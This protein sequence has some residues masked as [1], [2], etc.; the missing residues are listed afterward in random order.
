MDQIRAIYKF[1]LSFLKSEWRL[2]DYPIRYQH[3]PVEKITKSGHLQPIPW[4]V[5]IINWWTMSG[6]GQTREEAFEDLKQKFE[7]KRTQEA[8]LPR[9]GSRVAIAFVSTVQIESYETIARE[10]LSKI[11]NMNFDNCFI[12]DE[13]SLWDFHT[14]ESNETYYAKIKE[15]FNVNVSDIEDAKLGAIFRRIYETRNST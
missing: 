4:T 6:Y 1:I 15:I 2:D 9:P 13:S 3:Y 8:S 11:L 7:A 14:S 10:F 12:S 5:Q